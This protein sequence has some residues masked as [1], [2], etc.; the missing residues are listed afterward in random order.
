MSASRGDVAIP[1]EKYVARAKRFENELIAVG[2]SKT[3]ALRLSA[4]RY[5]Y[6]LL[7][8]QSVIKS[9][10][11]D[12]EHVVGLYYE[13]ANMMKFH[14]IRDRLAELEENS[15]WD[16]IQKSVIEDDLS[17]VLE[18]FT[19]LVFQHGH[20]S[21][22]KIDFLCSKDGLQLILKSTTRLN[23]SYQKCLN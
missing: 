21:R 6:Q 4:I 23:K 7:S 5:A 19:L 22:H 3:I 10:C 13:I 20:G 1:A 11:G 18:K 17:S 12:P 2:V 16:A 9:T 15:R 14:K 8:I